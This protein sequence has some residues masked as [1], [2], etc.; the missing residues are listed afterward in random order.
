MRLAIVLFCGVFVFGQS[1]QAAMEGALHAL[2]SPS[3]VKAGLTT[4]VVMQPT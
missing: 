4:I 2:V 1:G 3:A